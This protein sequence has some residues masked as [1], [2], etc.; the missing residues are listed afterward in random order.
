MKSNKIDIC[1][2]A[3]LRIGAQP[4]SSLNSNSAEAN[5]VKN[6]FDQIYLNEL[7]N[8]SWRFAL[9][10]LKL[11]LLNFSESSMDERS[12]AQ[13]NFNYCHQLPVDLIRLERIFNENISVI[14]NYQ[15]IKNGIYS[16]EQKLFA[17]Y[18]HPVDISTLPPYFVQYLELSLAYQLA[19]PLGDQ[20]E[21]ANY[22]RKMAD[23]QF[24]TSIYL[25]S[26]SY[27]HPAID[28][29]EILAARNI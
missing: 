9:R 19:I 16:D 14:T 7:A 8:H 28:L 27:Q 15:I 22:Y 4:I 21:K 20:L 26:Q 3:S 5:L 1:S 18:I 11:M 17:E 10:H 6:L 13:T 23:D 12:D 29:S 24:M 25:D 2:R